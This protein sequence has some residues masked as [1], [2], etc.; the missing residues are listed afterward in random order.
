MHTPHKYFA[1]HGSEKMI[2]DVRMGPQALVHN[3]TIYIVY[4]A[5]EHDIAAHPHIIAYDSG[6]KSWSDPVKLG[7]NTKY[8]HHFAPI[9]W[10]DDDEHLHVLYGCHITPG[11]HLV[12]REA[13]SIL[14]WDEGPPIAKT[15]SY[16]TVLRVSDKQ[17]VLFYRALGHLGFWAY[18]TSQDGGY[19]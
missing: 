2:F 11:T 3:D 18:R 8:D 19:S 10:I 14:E 5:N 4:Q 15:I 6:T 13:G 9:L 16:P 1:N 12:S 7:D 17:W